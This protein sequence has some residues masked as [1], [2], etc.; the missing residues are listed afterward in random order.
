METKGDLWIHR[1]RD[2]L[3]W[4]NSV[5][6]APE[7]E[8]VDDPNPRSGK[9]KLYVYY[10]KCSGWSN[11]DG[12][13]RVLRWEELHPRAKEFL[14]SEGTFQQLSD[15]NATY[16]ETLVSGRDLIGWH[17]RPDWDKRAAQAKHGAVTVFDSRQKTIAR[18]AATAFDTIAQSGSASI[19]T[20]KDK[21]T[22][23]QDRKA[24]EN[25]IAEL[26]HGK[27]GACALT[28]LRM[29]FDGDEGDS[30]LRCSLDRID[31]GG[32]YERGNLQVVCKFA[33]RWKGVSENEWFLGMIG[34]IRWG[35]P[36]PLR[37]MLRGDEGG[38]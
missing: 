22:G 5:E 16:A 20:K 29:L 35:G 13:G 15:D 4:A 23:F 19:V 37:A 25:Y 8:V 38:S 14:S 26:I 18:M 9:A 7:V 1:Q 30:E 2:E 10:K 31:S 3:W 12:R 6:A 27:D 33:N 28:G 32:H 11:Q 24:L 21:T 34:S 17:S 36:G